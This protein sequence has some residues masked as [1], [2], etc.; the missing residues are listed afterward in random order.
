MV[1]NDSVNDS[2]RIPAGRYPFHGNLQRRPAKKLILKYLQ[3][4]KLYLIKETNKLTLTYLKL[5]FVIN[6]VY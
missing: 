6:Y 1:V 3:F 4:N 5:F 2:T